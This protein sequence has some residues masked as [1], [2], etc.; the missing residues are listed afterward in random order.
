MIEMICP[1]CG[2]KLEIPE[3]YMGK[4][5]G[6]RQCRNKFF[7]P[8]IMQENKTS[9]V[10]PPELPKSRIEETKKDSVPKSSES[11]VAG[12]CGCLVLLLLFFFVFGT[13][14][15]DQ[16]PKNKG[17]QSGSSQYKP[18]EESS[19]DPISAFVMSQSFVKDRLK[20]PATAEFP[21][22]DESM[23]TPLG[24]EKYIVR[25]YV[26]AQNAFGALIRN[27]YTCRLAYQ[28]NDKWLLE[29][30]TIEAK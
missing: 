10:N 7:V 15:E 8:R 21:W 22:Y 6:C 23:V 16:A 26:D 29:D 5:V 18:Q 2:S 3:D 12:G 27:N 25:S 4:E 9:S 14:S 19:S 13:G 24:K 17:K 30:I 28:G 11:A 1:F 20:A